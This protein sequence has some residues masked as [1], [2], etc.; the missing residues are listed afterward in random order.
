MI[1]PIELRHCLA[2]AKLNL[3]LHVLGQRDDGYHEIETV[4]DLIDLQDSM[5]FSIRSDG[6]IMR[7]GG[8]HGLA[9]DSDL[10]VRA[11]RL[12]AAASETRLGADIEIVKRIPA[13]GGLGG[14]SS[15]AAT[16]LL[17]LNRLWGINWP[18]ARVARLG[19]QLGADVPVFV[20]GTAALATGVG[21]KITALALPRQWYVVVAPPAIVPTTEIFSAP[22]LTRDSKPLKISPLSRQ[23]IGLAGRNDL[24]PVASSRYPAV[25]QALTAL[26]Q[27]ARQVLRAGKPSRKGALSK[28]VARAGARKSGVAGADGVEAGAGPG[29]GAGAGAASRASAASRAGA[30]SRA[31][32]RAD[33]VVKAGDVKAG[34]AGNGGQDEANA[35]WDAARMSGSGGCV[36]YPA[37]DRESAERIAERVGKS[38]IGKVHVVE[39]LV[40]HPM[41]GWAFA[42]GLVR[43]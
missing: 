33:G 23:N 43:R 13:G 1:E 19:L 32:A 21:E 26:T 15:N 36:F 40:E 28:G 37:P 34:A 4:F 30:A 9:H 41:R 17:A 24:E 6:A 16:T 12:L 39:S 27:A 2:P 3:Y 8:L 35:P 22:E 18:I 29:V 14:G 25:Q 42:K 7:R 5:H 31:S 38:N 10:S 20:H 11:A